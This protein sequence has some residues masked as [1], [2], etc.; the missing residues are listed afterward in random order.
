MTQRCYRF[1][2]I[3]LLASAALTQVAVAGNGKITGAVKSS[4]GA[5]VPG[6]N[7][8][9]VG[10]TLGAATD[11]SG[12]YFILNVPPGTYRVRASA[13]GYAPQVVVGVLIESDQIL[14]L[15]FTLQSEAVGLAEIV[16]QAERPLVDRS[17]TASKST[18]T[19]DDISSLPI[20]TSVG[21][22]ATSASAYNGFIRGGRINETK[23][24]VDGVDVSDQFYTYAGDMAHTPYLVYNSVPR[25]HGSELSKIGDFS[26]NSVEQVSVNTGAVGAEYSSATAGLVN[27]ALREG[28]GPL[29]GSITGRVSQF[30]GL[31]YNGPDVYW[32]DFLYFKE[33]SDLQYRVDSLRARRA[34]GLPFGTTLPAD[35]ARL[36]RY[37]YANGKYLNEKPTV[38]FEGSL[39]GDIMQ[40]WGFF[41]TGKY[42]NSYGRLPNE[43]AREIG[44]TLKTQY[45]IT[46]DIKVTGLGILTDRGRFFGWKNRGYQESARFYLEGV[47]KN[48]GAD[49]IGSLKLTHILD[50]S[51]FYEVQASITSN[52][53]RTGYSDDNGDGFC[54]LDEDGDFITLETLA[55][56]NKY[57]NNTDLTKFFRNQD[58]QASSTSTPFNAGGTTARLARPG[59]FYENLLYS[60]FTVKGDYTNQL[61]AN[62]RLQVG[63]QARFHNVDM[64]RR[65]SFLG[66]VDAKQQYYIEQWNPKPT[67][68]GGYIQDRMEYAGLIINLGARVDTWNPDALEFTNY[69]APYRD[70]QVSVDTLTGVPITVTQR[71]TQRSKKVDTYVFLSPRIGVSH[72]IS[73]VAAMYFSYSRN[74]LPPPY[75]RV[76]ANYNNFG[77]TSLPNN[78]SVL[79][80]PYK[81]NNYEL[82]IQWEFVPKFA[83][84]FNAYLRDIEDYGYYSYNVI[85][86][87]GPYGTNY[88]VGFSAGYA[89]SRGVEVTLEGQRQSFFDGILTVSGRATYTY[90]YI[91]ASAFA[92]LDPKMQ[93]SFST[94]NGDS[95]R[96]AGGLPIDD[97]NF[98][99]KI[100]TD[101]VGGAS[102]L[103]GGYDRTHRITYQLILGFPEDIVLSSI[104]TF[105]SGFFYP[106]YTTAD[107]R[108]IGREFAEGPW[109]QQVDLRLEKGFEF[110]G[111]RLS[112]FAEVINAFNWTNIIGYD[113]LDTQFLW[114]KSN[115]A[116]S[117]NPTG[118]YV[119]PVG[120]D[121]SYFYG[122][123]REFYFGARLTF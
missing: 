53:T 62:H 119:R 121:G 47:P 110:E 99:N 79:Q 55:Q 78:P 97:I 2:A 56:A 111:V 9:V 18:I 85:P 20:R 34:A 115:A 91:K 83:L 71:Q 92:G 45:N 109:N 36:G 26:F 118:P 96:L 59:F 21:L 25:F 84:N 54:A 70:V 50:P 95:A 66:A 58:E 69:F 33:K 65:A 90:S 61:T 73:D 101:V 27:Y 100:Q 3:V 6:V 17:L 23:T 94:A 122:F 57:I 19:S 4:D 42:F 29:T 107:A 113:N 8:V 77:N 120:A 60:V 104:G 38:E 15:D 98:Y 68:F 123:P 7:V 76:Y 81:S 24:I 89:D 30:K 116:G 32:N 37:T 40:D 108:T 112:V 48:D 82:G 12:N 28:R 44:L 13:V 11:P 67:E 46:G 10:T 14:T 49:I 102:T 35:S 5:A 41:F 117:P 16:I 51:S 80:K 43:F 52:Q 1:L 74:S 88:Y 86:R 114:E 106:K 93:T 63:G 105:Q 39:S 72:P 103:T 22:I 75:S 31:R 87:S 64:L